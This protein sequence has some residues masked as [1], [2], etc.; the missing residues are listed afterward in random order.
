MTDPHT[1]LVIF[2]LLIGLIFFV[3]KLGEITVDMPA[4]LTLEITEFSTSCGNVKYDC[5]IPE[6]GGRFVEMMPVGFKPIFEE[7][8]ISRYNMDLKSIYTV[9][10]DEADETPLSCLY[11]ALKQK[12]SCDFELLLDKHHKLGVKVLFKQPKTYVDLRCL[13]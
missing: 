5:H 1:A 2:V 6:I 7:I 13:A 3:F 10:V 11:A 12:Q 9:A 4:Q 8:L